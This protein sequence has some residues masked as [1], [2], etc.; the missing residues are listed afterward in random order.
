MGDKTLTFEQRLRLFKR[1]VSEA[2]ILYEARS[3]RYFRPKRDRLIAK[4]QQARKVASK[5]RRYVVRP[6][7]LGGFEDGNR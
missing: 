2:G 7:D 4:R 5:M 6:A 3:R 1:K